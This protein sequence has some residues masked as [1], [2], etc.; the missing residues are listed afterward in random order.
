MPIVDP[1]RRHR[2]MHTLVLDL[3]GTAEQT[4]P[5]RSD[6]TSLL[7]LDGVPRDSRGLTDMLVVTTTVGMVDGVH[8]YTTSPGPA[9]ALG[10]ELHVVSPDTSIT[11]TSLLTLCLARDAFMRG[12]SVRPPPATIPT[13]PR[14]PLG[15]TFLAPDGSL[16]RVLP[17]SGLWP[18]TVT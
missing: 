17:S 3:L 10:G 11:T 9:V 5:P 1:Y 18:M 16:T 4:R 7:T 2:I 14:H 6:E 12:L 8:G 15:R 13:I